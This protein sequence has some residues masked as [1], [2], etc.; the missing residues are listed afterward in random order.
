VNGI[1]Q[2]A[3]PEAFRFDEL[4]RRFLGAKNGPCRV[5]ADR[6]HARYFGAELD[7]RSLT[8]G[9]NARIAPTRSE[10]WLSQSM[11]AHDLTTQR[12]VS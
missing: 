10:D 6:V 7:E 2:L 12:R 9:E 1:V 4:A 5:T 8:P 3:G 11:A